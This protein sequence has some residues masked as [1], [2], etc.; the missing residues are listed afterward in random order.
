MSGVVGE[1]FQMTNLT[2][3]NNFC[4]MKY[5][6]KSIPGLADAGVPLVMGMAPK[7]RPQGLDRNIVHTTLISMKNNRGWVG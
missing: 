4:F 2:V 3:L 5:A 7:L 1:K 6:Q